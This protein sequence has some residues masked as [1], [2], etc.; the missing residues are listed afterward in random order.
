VHAWDT[1]LDIESLVVDTTV[2]PTQVRLRVSGRSAPD[3]T[4]ELAQSLADRLEE[5][6]FLRIRFR[7]EFSAGSVALDE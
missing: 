6:V 1:T 3:S 4:D 5:P 7:P 2:E